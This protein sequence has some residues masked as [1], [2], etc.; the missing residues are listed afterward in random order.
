MRA[1]IELLSILL[2]IYNIILLARVLMSW[3]RVD[4]YNPVARFLYDVTEPLLRPIRDVLQQIFPSLRMIDLS[5]IVLF[6]LIGVV[7]NMLRQFRF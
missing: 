4:P 5:P 1:V 2:Y 6:L 7:Q 3:I